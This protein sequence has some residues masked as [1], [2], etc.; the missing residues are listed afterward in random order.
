MTEPRPRRRSKHPT[1]QAA[2]LLVVVCLA[3]VALAVM[4]TFGLW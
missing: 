1:A 3:L 4:S 2:G